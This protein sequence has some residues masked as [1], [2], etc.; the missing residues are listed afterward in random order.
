MTASGVR[1]DAVLDELE[2]HLREDV[3]RQSKCGISTQ[4]AFGIAVQNLGKTNMLKHE[5]GKISP[6]CSV[7]EKLM[8]GIC[9]VF[10]GF[11]VLLSALAVFLCYERSGERI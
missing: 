4:Q 2:S 10:V 9:A 5:F 8:I 6:A 7:T 1:S 11:I 3:D